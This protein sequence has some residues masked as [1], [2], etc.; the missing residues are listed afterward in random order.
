MIIKG[1]TPLSVLLPKGTYGVTVEYAGQGETGGQLSM[2]LGQQLIRVQSFTVGYRV[3]MSLPLPSI[4]RRTRRLTIR[5]GRRKGW[6][7]V[8]ASVV[9]F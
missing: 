7:C 5:S 9:E 3:I 2:M 1:K 8:V 6:A 4:L